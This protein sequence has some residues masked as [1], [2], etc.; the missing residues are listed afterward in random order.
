MSRGTS[1]ASQGLRG[2][3]CRAAEQPLPA[4]SAQKAKILFHEGASPLEALRPGSRLRGR[5]PTSEP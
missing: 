4:F 1:A 5:A 2:G 3:V